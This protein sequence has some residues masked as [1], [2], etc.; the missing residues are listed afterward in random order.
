M[1]VNTRYSV[2]NVK[3]IQG[4][5]FFMITKI[6]KRDGRKVPF[7]IEKISKAIYKAAVSVGGKDY[8]EAEELAAKVCEKIEKDIYE[9]CPTVEQ[10]QDIVEKVLIEEGHVATAKAYILYRAERTRQRELKSDIMKTYEELT[11]QD[12]KDNDVKRENANVKLSTFI[13]STNG[14][15]T[16]NDCP[17][18]NQLSQSTCDATSPNNPP[19]TNP[20]TINSNIIHVFL[21]LVAI[22]VPPFFIF[23]LPV[24]ANHSSTLITFSLLLYAI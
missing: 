18:A 11:F 22:F 13:F 4:M 12:A 23:Y 21:S 19:I 16:P 24:L 14:S 17:Y 5:V 10:I 20:A 7:N 6:V 1:T 15:F 2:F 3:N 8:E 9:D